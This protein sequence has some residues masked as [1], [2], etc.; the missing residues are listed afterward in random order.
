MFW[1]YAKPYLVTRDIKDESFGAKVF[2]EE[3]ESLLRHNFDTFN[4]S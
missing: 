1:D 3:I 4:Q 2:R